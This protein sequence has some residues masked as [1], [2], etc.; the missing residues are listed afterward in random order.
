M[1]SDM[2]D[3]KTLP[4]VL[5]AH[6]ASRV[7]GGCFSDHGCLRVISHEDC[8]SHDQAVRGVRMALR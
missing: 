2:S 1:P 5:S 7:G 8:T 3:F 6:W 4:E